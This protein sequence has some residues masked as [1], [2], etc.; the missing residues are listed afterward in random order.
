MSKPIAKL[1]VCRRLH[2]PFLR[3]LVGTIKCHDKYREHKAAKSNLNATPFIYPFAITNTLRTTF[4]AGLFL[5]PSDDAPSGWLALSA[6]VGLP[7]ALWVYKVRPAAQLV[8]YE[9]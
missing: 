5:Q 7:L 1:Y 8:G 2:S 4:S 9:S 6:F 3:N